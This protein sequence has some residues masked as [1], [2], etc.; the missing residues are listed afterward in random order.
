MSDLMFYIYTISM[1]IEKSSSVQFLMRKVKQVRIL[2]LYAKTVIL[3]KE[4]KKGK[5]NQQKTIGQLKQ[6]LHIKHII[7]RLDI[8]TSIMHQENFENFF[9]IYLYIE[10]QKGIILSY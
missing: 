9:L 1:P 6:S 7:L 10:V 3:K 2:E 8:F 4:K 5:G